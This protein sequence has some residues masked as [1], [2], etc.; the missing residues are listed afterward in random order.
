MIARKSNILSVAAL[1]VALLFACFTF[2]KPTSSTPEKPANVPSDAQ[3]V[4]GID[5]GDWLIC[6]EVSTRTMTCTVFA[7][8]T[9]V[10]VDEGIF[11]FDEEHQSKIGSDSFYASLSYF[12]G[13]RIKLRNGG[14][15]EKKIE[16]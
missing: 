8:V 3:W 13:E 10:L 14:F 16:K 5:G 2:I 12:D 15:Y 9:G 6:H 11:T 7:D 4:G 1:I